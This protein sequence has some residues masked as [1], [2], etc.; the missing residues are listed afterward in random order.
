MTEN[1]HLSALRGQSGYEEWGLNVGGRVVAGLAMDS[2]VVYVASRDKFLCGCSRLGE[3]ILWKIRTEGPIVTTPLAVEGSVYF[4]AEGDGLYAANSK[5]KVKWKV[6]G[7]PSIVSIG[8]QAMI[9]VRQCDNKSAKDGASEI[10]IIE[11]DSGKQRSAVKMPGFT[12]FP[13][14]IKGPEIF[15]LSTNG[16]IIALRRF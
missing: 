15:C 11:T 1:G 13:M 14:N 2:R 4:R 9:L 16:Y 6:D 12:I 3:G 8:K 5:G 7:Q 10:V